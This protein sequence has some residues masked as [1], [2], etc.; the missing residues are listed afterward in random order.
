[1]ESEPRILRLDAGGVRQAL[2][3]LARV[4]HDCVA[5]GDSVSF[6][7]GLSLDEARAYYEAL[8]PEVE[9]G[10]RVVLAA[11]DAD[12]L[13]GSVQF[14]HAWP[15]NSRYRAEVTKLVVHPNAR[16]RG[17]G[18]GLMERVEVEALADGKTLLVLDTVS[19]GIADGLYERLGWTRFGII[20]RYAQDPGGTPCDAAFFY[21][22]L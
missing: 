17:I 19:G 6:L 11:Y 7:A 8:V 10:T 9:L 12:E 16:G 4:L 18:R 15:P 21:K 2:P 14:V 13:V 20:P 1:V 22:H 3:E 5:A